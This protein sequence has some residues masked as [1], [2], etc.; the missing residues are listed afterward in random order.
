MKPDP[1]VP[2]PSLSKS[3]L[4]HP[5]TGMGS[6]SFAAGGA[7]ASETPVYPPELFMR[8]VAAT[9]G[10]GKTLPDWRAV[11]AMISAPEHDTGGLAQAPYFDRDVRMDGE[12]GRMQALAGDDPADQAAPPEPLWASLGLGQAPAGAAAASGVSVGV[13][14]VASS[15]HLSSWVGWL[16][17]GLAA[18]AVGTG[19]ETRKSEEPDTEPPPDSAPDDDAED[20]AVSE[21]VETETNE[22]PDGAL[23]TPA[24]KSSPASP[25][26]WDAAVLPFPQGAQEQWLSGGHHS[27]L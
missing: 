17:G 22:G 8:S 1:G 2:V 4:V 25:A 24:D 16:A 26:M 11:E 18:F 6:S 12:G 13:G 5:D 10:G 15:A 9:A 27:V 23:L 20:E 19:L 14:S 21:G 3:H 7:L